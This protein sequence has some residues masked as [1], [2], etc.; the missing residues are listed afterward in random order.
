[1]DFALLRIWLEIPEQRV[2]P[3]RGGGAD[4]RAAS[5]HGVW[6]KRIAPLSPSWI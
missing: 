1:M 2:Q 3:I 6:L 5:D 4:H